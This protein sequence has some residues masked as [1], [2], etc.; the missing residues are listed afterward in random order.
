MNHLVW[1]FKEVIYLSVFGGIL[2]ILIL[3][4]KKIF[5]KT[6]SPRWHFYI[7]I[8]LL[9]RLMLPYT[10]ESS[11]SIYNLFY[12]AAE[13]VNIP[14]NE[15]NNPL[16]D[17]T[18]GN[19]SKA[20]DTDKSSTPDI[21]TGNLPSVPAPLE[22]NVTAPGSK[23]E[24]EKSIFSRAYMAVKAAATVPVISTLAI[25]WLV[26]VLVFTVYTIWNNIVFAL[27]I[28]N[29]YTKLEDRRINGI[30][31]GC[32]ETMNIRHKIILLTTKKLRTPSLYAILNPKILVSK[33]YMDQLSDTEI[34]YIFLHELSHYKRGDILIN[35]VLA[36]LQIV[37][38]FNPLIWYAFYKIHEDCE[39]ACDAEALKH[40]REEEYQSYGNTIIKLIRLFSESNFI[41]ATAGIGKNKAS[42]KRRILMISKFKKSKW[43]SNLLTVILIFIIAAAGLTG[44]NKSTEVVKDNTADLTDTSD[45]T[46]TTDITNTTDTIDTA[47]ITDTSE[48][49]DETTEPENTVSNTLDSV[50]SSNESGSDLVPAR[51]NDKPGVEQNPTDG[52]PVL[53]PSET[54]D[55]VLVPSET[56]DLGYYGVWNIKK[57]LAF[58]SAGT[59]SREDAD[60]LIG[61]ELSFSTDKAT[62]FGDKAALL[63]QI[64]SRPVYKENELTKDDF[65]ANY[66]MTFDK[67]GINTDAVTEVSVS[68]AN[69]VVCSFL[70]ID[71]NKLILS[72][73]GTYFELERK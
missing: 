24:D 64:S 48:V 49:T 59:Y 22:E 41:P 51:D 20:G 47:D 9:V 7:W 21:V 30:L 19:N 62:N 2:S 37:Y 29:Q 67:L 15:I 33:E 40:I 12:Q 68:D 54:R 71:D 56:R 34:E 4:V 18:Y 57:V 8:L 38:F 43:T 5:K 55:S 23:Q 72:G 65:V 35:W 25:I 58:G 26:I 70:V 16:Q 61:K 13:W 36:L 28:K 73:G 17:N 52:D 63:E 50:D 69:G 53:V 27:K 32:L 45:T 44:C 60:A 11:F 39:I 3:L 6:L 42:Y 46:D 66:R 31:K 10:P 14:I 1:I